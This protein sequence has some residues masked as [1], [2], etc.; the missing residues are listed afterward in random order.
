MP[1]NSRAGALVFEATL[2]H[3]LARGESIDRIPNV[4]EQ[5]QTFEQFAWKWF[6]EYVVT[7]NKYS[8]Q[9]MKK[10]T[11]RGALIPFFG[12]MPVAEITA[13]HIEQYKAQRVKD[14]LA[15]KTIKN[16]LL[17]LTKC[18]TTALNAT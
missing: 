18:L 4:A 9:R 16:H 17:V 2:R 7:N 14:G 11:L 10:H 5:K 1:E 3:K 12:K 15:N 13:Y 6:E 8:K